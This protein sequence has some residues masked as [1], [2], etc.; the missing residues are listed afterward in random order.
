MRPP[1]DDKDAFMKRTKRDYPELEAQVM[2]T[3]LSIYTDLRRKLLGEPQERDAVRDYERF[4]SENFFRSKPVSL[5]PKEGTLKQGHPVDTVHIKIGD[6]KQFPVYDLG[7]GMQSLII[8][9]YPVFLATG[10]SFFFFEEPDL[11]M[12]PGLQRAL[13]EALLENKQHQYFMTTHSNH[14]LDLTMDYKDISVFHFKRK[15]DEKEPK[16]RINCM[17]SRDRAVLEDLGV[18][19]SSVFLTNATIWVEGVTD[20]KYLRIFMK[21]FLADD[22]GLMEKFGDLKEDFHYS[23]VEY[24]GSNLDHWTFADEKDDKELIKAVRLCSTAIVI[25]DGDVK[26]KGNRAER[27]ERDLG[28]RFSVLPCKEIENLV[29]EAMLRKF[30]EVEL[31]AAAVDPDKISASDYSASDK[32]IGKYLDDLL[33]S[34]DFGEEST[35]LKRHK[36]LALC[37]KCVAYAADPDFEWQL[38]APARDL[39]GKVFEHILQNNPIGRPKE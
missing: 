6:D 37:D 17:S 26:L 7:D 2:F 3:G 5:I 1:D 34:K 30:V 39:C 29:P 16:F 12:H 15:T 9:T 36:K 38:T 19:N 14:L 20:R 33:N 27:F 25:A 32:G 22:R 21:K 13:I 28:D 11:A 23:F 10:P 4:L 31:S 35:T 8:A 18:R 24:Q